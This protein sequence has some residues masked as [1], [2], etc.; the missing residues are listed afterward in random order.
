MAQQGGGCTNERLRIM[1][2]SLS[3]PGLHRRSG[4][5]GARGGWQE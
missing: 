2:F 3:V 5:G 1:P 4:T